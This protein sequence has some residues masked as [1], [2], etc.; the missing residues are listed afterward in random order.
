MARKFLSTKPL[1]DSLN[2]WIA[3]NIHVDDGHGHGHEHQHEHGSDHSHDHHHSHNE[4]P[5][6]PHVVHHSSPEQHH[7]SVWKKIH[8]NLKKVLHYLEI[9]SQYVR[10]GF[11]R[12]KRFVYPLYEQYKNEFKKFRRRRF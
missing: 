12:M 8:S 2:K 3:E 4:H 7:D 5:H 1:I 9:G 6:H 10:R 11:E